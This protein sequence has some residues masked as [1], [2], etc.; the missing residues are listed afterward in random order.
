MKNTI[1]VLGIIALIAVI[2]F[3]FTVLS[4]TG[5]D[6][7]GDNYIPPENKPVKDRWGKW[8]AD[9]ATATLDFSVDNNGVCK[10]T[11]GGI[12]QPNDNTDE[13]GRWKANA[14]YDYTAKA[15]KSY[16]Y[17]FEAWTESG[18]RELGF[19]YNTDNDN[20]I[21][22]N[23]SISLTTTRKTYTVYGQ[24]LSKD[25]INHVEFQCA[26]QLGTF[27]VKILEIKEYTP[28]EDLPVKDRW[29]KWI[30]PTS[31][32]TLDFSVDGDGV[33]TITVGGKAESN[34]D[35]WS[36]A[37]KAIA[38][39]S[40]TENEGK[41]YI[42][43]FEAWTASGDRELHVEYFQNNNDEVGLSETKP[44]TTE[45][46]TYTIYGQ[47][48]PRL[49]E[50]PALRFQCA[51]QLGT[52]YVKILEIKEYTVSPDQ[53]AIDEMESW[54][55]AQPAN[56]PTTAYTYKLNLFNYNSV[57]DVRDILIANDTKYVI[58]D[59]SGSTITEIPAYAF[60]SFTDNTGCATLVGIIFPNSVTSIV[61]G[62]FMGCTSLASVTI[63]NSVTSIGEWAFH[64]CAGL[65]SITIPDSVTSIEFG[66]FNGCT[67]L[68]SV[69]IPNSVTSI[70][71]VAF[72][73]CTSLTSVNIPNSVTSI[74]EAAFY[75]CT[76]LTSVITGNA[77]TSLNGFS[78]SGSTNLTSVTIGNSVTSI[79]GYAFEYCASLASV[80]IGNSVSSIGS[81][82]FRGC[83]SLASVTIGNSVTSIGDNAFIYCTGLTSI[84]IP[85]SVTSIGDSAFVYCTGLT[86]ITRPTSVTSIGESAFGYCRNLTSIT[87]QGT[88]AA[89][90]LGSAF[91]G[92]LRDKYLAGGIGTYTTT[93]PV[94]YYSVWTKQ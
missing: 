31:T 14:Q 48:L 85:N 61:V 78:F 71:E 18:T 80:T 84:T 40:Y 21:Y 60:N 45:R 50:Y 77:V 27:Y 92:D 4:L 53:L 74:G 63:P 86:S 11:V 7:G 25:V 10:I 52:F 67:S 28:A 55:S 13:W 94:D 42:Y 29:W 83:A 75:E 47:V 91:S 90:N 64:G 93:A 23:E 37:W 87:F 79:G 70:G 30:E 44:I 41:S 34:T 68:T 15:G 24:P 58:L 3:S 26:D 51:D 8:I 39:Y 16:I 36:V 56:T 2:C 33:C 35:G 17:T 5:C 88:I 65:T 46:Q 9:D 32:A 38:A 73:E 57:S 59:L 19:Q 54:L 12:A 22:L 69:T 20:N 82:A 81:S 89:D 1:K 6:N 49:G 72:Y 66:T 43:T 62:A 76:S